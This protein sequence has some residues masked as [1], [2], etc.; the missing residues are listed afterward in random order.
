MGWNDFQSLPM[1]AN[2]GIFAGA[3]VL[4]WIA[5]SRLAGYAD[6]V[7]ARTGFGEAVIGMVGLGVATSLPEIVT[8]L[9]GSTIGNVSLV[10]GNLF[11]GVAQQIT[12]LAVVD[13][14]AVKGALTSL[15]PNPILLL[16]GVILLLV[17]AVALVGGTLRE[18]LSWMGVGL[19]PVLVGLGYLA[20]FAVTSSQ[21]K[22]LP[23]WRPIESDERATEMK[24]VLEDEA[25]GQGISQT[26]LYVRIG[27]AAVAI[28]VA[29][30]ALTL[31]GDAL[32]GQTGLGSSFVGVA[33]VAFSTSLPEVSTTLG[34]VR[35]GNHEMAVSNILGTNILEV[36]LF[37]LAD[38]AY[39]EGPILAEL[40]R[41]GTLAAALG[42]VVTCLLLL[43]LLERRDR[44]VMRM[45][46]DSLAI[47]V[48]YAAGL[49]GLYHLR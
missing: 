14:I 42:L 47:L 43:G 19:T 12:V 40:D 23:R 16:Q 27:L 33:F 35:R 29:G 34:A 46:V 13:L 31:T 45:G 5:G 32:A 7:S 37:L 2:L 41:S 20:A 17:L 36:A 28:L 11:G 26:T 25:A 44:T 10:I 9:I 6:I 18:P 22:Y 30:T 21:K 38:I 3:A 1:A 8:T 4:V 48:A 49:A 24:P 15:V 39:R